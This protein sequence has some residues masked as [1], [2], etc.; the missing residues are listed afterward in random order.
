[1]GAETCADSAP[2][3]QATPE[4]YNLYD[5]VILLREGRI[6]YHGPREALPPYMA[7]IGFEPPAAP[8]PAPGQ[9]VRSTSDGDAPALPAPGQAGRATSDGEAPAPAPAP[10]QEDVADWLLSVITQ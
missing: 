4:V 2:A 6:V 10:A 9:A 7:G 3:S 1:M 8:L 5:D